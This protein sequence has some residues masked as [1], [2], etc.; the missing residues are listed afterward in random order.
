MTRHHGDD[1]F[2]CTI[3]LASMSNRV[4]TERQIRLFDLWVEGLILTEGV[5]PV[6]LPG[7]YW[8]AQ[9]ST[10]TP[11][12]SSFVPKLVQSQI[13]HPWRI[14]SQIAAHPLPESAKGVKS[15]VAAIRRG[16]SFRNIWGNL[17]GPVALIRLI[18]L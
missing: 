11:S 5:P 10:A 9:F 16:V 18:A 15:V 8:V 1:G 6:D 3:F 4:G 14:A 13:G 2:F 12:G 17:S 7:R